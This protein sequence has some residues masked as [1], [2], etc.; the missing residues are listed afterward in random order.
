VSGPVD[1][2]PG[3]RPFELASHFTVEEV[4]GLAAKM[5]GR[6]RAA[7]LAYAQQLQREPAVA[8]LIE[9]AKALPIFSTQHGCDCETCTAIVRFYAALANIGET[10]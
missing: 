1:V 2:L 7:L 5:Q 4:V 6:R 9:A 3:E 10:K 8:E